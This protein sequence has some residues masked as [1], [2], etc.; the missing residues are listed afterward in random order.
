MS[1]PMASSAHRPTDVICPGCREVFTYQPGESEAS[2]SSCPECNASLLA[3]LLDDGPPII[4]LFDVATKVL[5][6]PP[7]VQIGPSSESSTSTDSLDTPLG[8]VT[9]DVRIQIAF[10]AKSAVAAIDEQMQAIRKLA[11]KAQKS[12]KFAADNTEGQK[13]R[14]ERNVQQI[15]STFTSQLEASHREVVNQAEVKLKVELHDAYRELLEGTLHE[16]KGLDSFQLHVER[17]CNQFTT[18]TNSLMEG[19]EQLGDAITDKL[20]KTVERFKTTIDNHKTSVKNEFN[21]FDR[22]RADKIDNAF[23]ESQNRLEHNQLQLEK[24]FDL[25]REGL[26]HQLEF[27]EVDVARVTDRITAEVGRVEALAIDR[28]LRKKRVDKNGA[29]DLSPQE[30]QEIAEAA[31]DAALTPTVVKQLISQLAEL[32]KRRDV[33]QDLPNL[34]DAIDDEYRKWTTNRE[35]DNSETAAAV[36][37]ALEKIRRRVDGW[38]LRHDIECFPNGGDKFE[39][40]LHDRISTRQDSTMEPDRVAETERSGYRFKDGE[41]LRRAR[42]ITS[43]LPDETNR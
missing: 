5:R 34:F 14:I 31:F 39:N 3:I 6:D 38:M 40:V 12:V 10:V 19:V 1:V 13:S 26:I 32:Q 20:C 22:S 4:E 33:C 23:S 25:H 16:L 41:L 15:A 2:K 7:S 42:V 24:Q 28:K 30:T 27:F 29:G 8:S 21:E 11:D 17:L 43:T 37:E 35:Q 36:C 9:D 18:K